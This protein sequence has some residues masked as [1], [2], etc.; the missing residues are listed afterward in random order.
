MR[1]NGPPTLPPLARNS[2]MMPWFH[3]CAMSDLPRPVD[4]RSMP[5]RLSPYAGR[6]RAVQPES[7]IP[8]FRPSLET[9][10]GDADGHRVDE[11]GV[12]PAPGPDHP[13]P[14]PLPL[15]RQDLLPRLETRLG[16]QP[17]RTEQ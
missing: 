12:R 9:V 3:S 7:P 5:P 11:V 14:P 2:S 6:A 17:E 10:P 4:F 8:V 1:S 13:P 15:D 16:V